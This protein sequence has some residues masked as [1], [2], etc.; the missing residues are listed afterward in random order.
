MVCWHF[1]Q[2]SIK[3]LI[4]YWL[5]TVNLFAFYIF[6]TCTNFYQYLLNR[7]RVIHKK[8]NFTKKITFFPFFNDFLLQNIIFHCQLLNNTFIIK[9]I[10]IIATFEA[11]PN[12]L[13]AP[14][15]KKS[16]VVPGFRLITVRE[17]RAR[18]FSSRNVCLKNIER[19]R[20]WGWITL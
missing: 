11:R 12:A 15:F 4:I 2:L 7:F 5:N 14:D 13:Y 20:L 6:E 17:W 3:L 19:V 1:S 16:L 10:M 8:L 18:V 9:Q